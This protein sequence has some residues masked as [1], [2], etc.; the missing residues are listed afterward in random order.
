[1]INEPPKPEPGSTPR[2]NTQLAISHLLLPCH[3][4][5]AEGI[6]Q[7]Y[8]SVLG[9]RVAAGG[10]RAEVVAGAG[11]KLVFKEVASLGPRSDEASGGRVVCFCCL[12]RE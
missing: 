6:A 7:F 12:Q 2:P 10:G 11:S 5:S 9:A 3:A 8:E 1:M 4:G